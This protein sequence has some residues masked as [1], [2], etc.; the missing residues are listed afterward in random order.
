LGLIGVVYFLAK[1]S[2]P[3]RPEEGRFAFV[4]MQIP[5]DGLSKARVVHPD[6]GP[7]NG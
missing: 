4:S 1:P 3:L 5:G 2:V 7:I 6:F